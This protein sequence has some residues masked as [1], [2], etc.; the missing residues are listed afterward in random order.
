MIENTNYELQRILYYWGL[1]LFYWEKIRDVYK[2]YTDQGVKNLK[3]S[4]LVPERL[5]FV[6]EAVKHLMKKEFHKMY[7]LIPTSDGRTYIL[8]HQYAYSLFDW[9]D[10]RQCDFKNDWELAEST[11]ILA[12]F[13]RTTLGFEPPVHSNMRDRL[14]K[15]LHH[16]QERYQE[17]LEFKG[18]AASSP[19]DPFAKTYLEHVNFFLP[20]AARAIKKMQESSYEELVTKARFEKPFCHGDPA[21]RNF[22]LTPQREIYVIDFDSCR[23][24]LPI[25]DII[26]FTRRVM[27]K[28]HWS[29]QTAKLLV[30]SYQEVYPLTRIEIEVMKAV[31]YFPQK[32]WR[33]SVR[34]FHQRKEYH[35]DKLLRKF[36]KYLTNGKSLARFQAEFEN[37]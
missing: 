18:I 29:Y 6:H 3:L 9:I 30:D 27:K 16:F 1:K 12:E 17:L 13:H 19:K 28:H 8:D 24:D 7:P 34:Y 32:F 2:V 11:R 5:L 31:F 20:M 22:I 33:L 23:L 21:A 35:H 36:Q 4:P 25:M 15:C 14:G 10:G 37:Y 26:K